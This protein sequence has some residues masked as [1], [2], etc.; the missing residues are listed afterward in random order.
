MAAFEAAGTHEARLDVMCDYL[1]RAPKENIPSDQVGFGCFS[2]EQQSARGTVRLHFGN[3]VT[4]QDGLGPLHSS[5]QRERLEELRS[6]FAYVKAHFADAKFVRGGSWL[7]HIEA[8][9]KLF[10]PSFGA[11]RSEAIGN[12]NF[13]GSSSWGQF[14][15][16]HGDIKPD[17]VAVFLNNLKSIDCENPAR[18]FPM[19]ALMTRASVEDFFAFYD[20]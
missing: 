15:N 14:L 13:S 4:H 3:R 10:P 8:Y 9:R 20:V 12:R 7:Y 19:P 6:L 18:V 1:A 2:L 16:H 11:S 5:H 17:L